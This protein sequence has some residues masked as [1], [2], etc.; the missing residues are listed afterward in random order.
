MK[1][2]LLAIPAV[3]IIACGSQKETASDS[4]KEDNTKT[5]VSSVAT[6]YAN[7]ITAAEMK[8]DLY[9][10]ASDEFEGRDTG[11]PGQKK[12]VE[13][14]KKE[15]QKMGIPSAYGTDN[16]FQ[17]I[18]AAYFE[19]K[20]KNDSE[21]VLAFI[22]GSEKPEEIIV[23]SAHLDHVGH[24]DGEI[25]NGADD[26]GSGTV[27]LL[28]MAEAFQL[29][30]KDGK[31]PKRSILILHVTGEE[32]GLFG[33]R[34]YSE[35]PVFP[36]A[37]TVADINVDMIGRVDPEHKD[38]PNYVYVIGADRLS[39]GLDAAVT[40]ANKNLK[41]FKLDYKYNDRNDPERI[42]YRSDH[43]NFAKNGVPSVFFFSGI[44]EDY[45]K[46]TDTPDKIDYPLM[47]T[48]TKL[49]FHTAWE[50]ANSD[51]RIKVDRDGK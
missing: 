50:I 18:P 44:H 51:E 9:I 13:F 8:T 33:S 34:Y 35:N 15:Y 12:A 48:R 32:K 46:P 3:C 43:Y 37:N 31:G 25:Y 17:S 38:A 19:G 20:A 27:A 1:N 28:E 6:T 22:E 2:L 11:E 26:D 24:H 14:L 23:L 39:T 40:K 49:I 47:T 45:H 7:T 4:V 10:Y 21:N 5:V 29:A 42:Y 30:K 36:L 41:D 16:Y